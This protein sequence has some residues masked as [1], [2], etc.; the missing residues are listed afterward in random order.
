MPSIARRSRREVTKPAATD[1]QTLLEL[2]AQQQRVAQVGL[3]TAG[4]AHDVDNHEQVISGVTF[5]ALR[6][7]NPEEWKRALEKVQ[8]QCCALSE[9]TRAFLGFVR[10]RDD[11]VHA[12]FRE[13]ALGD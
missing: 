9:M 1:R 2:L 5:L 3:V 6:R 13:R 10:R 11:A 7:R 8:A 4:L 12:K